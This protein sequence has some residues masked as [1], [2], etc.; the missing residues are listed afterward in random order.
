MLRLDETTRSL[1]AAI[2]LIAAVGVGLSLSLPLLSVEL[3]RMGVSATASGIAS[4]TSGFASILIAPFVPRIAARV[5]V[6]ALIAGAIAL[7]VATMI[8]FKL[9]MDYWAWLPLRFLLSAC[10]GV[11]FIL[12]EFWI[13]A[14]A[15]PERRG[16][17][18][19]IYAT[20]L[21]LGFASGPTLL[22]VVGTSGWAPYLTGSALFLLAALPLA[23]ARG[24]LPTVPAKQ[25][26][27]VFSYLAAAPLAAVAGFA[28]GAVETGAISLLPVFGLRNGLD[29]STAAL[30]V[31]A[32]ALGSILTQI[33]LGL[34]SDRVDRRY[35]LLVIAGLVIIMSGGIAFA[36]GRNTL[37][38]IGC[39]AI[40]GG[41]TGAFYTLGLAHLS[42]RFTAADL[43]GA[44]AAFVI[45]F[46][47]GVLAGAPLGGV[48]IDVSSRYGFAM[49]MGAFGV[50]VALAA[51]YELRRDIPGSTT[52][53]TNGL[54]A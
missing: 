16:V 32:V 31:S 54:A 49:A 10:L 45:M 3:E 23:L 46:N 1:V 43:V 17:I 37:A 41:F 36:A 13:S 20:V 47:V 39:L 19:G 51:L 53:S 35:L 12:S 8:G 30:L 52:G 14:A 42:S 25:R 24:R 7:A 5:G 44:N 28:S 27:P 26:Q 15:A 38:L 48:G 21:S 2:S 18:M 50:L 9:T 40:W 34:L 29:A 11:L 6:G 4:A 22:A 33:P